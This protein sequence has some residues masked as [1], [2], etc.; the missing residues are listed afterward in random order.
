MVLVL[1][2]KIVPLVN[3]TAGDLATAGDGCCSC[4]VSN[5]GKVTAKDMRFRDY[6]EVST[7]EKEKQ[8]LRM[9]KRRR[10]LE[11]FNMRLL[12]SEEP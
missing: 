9:E 11:E 8:R 6:T 10:S 3:E 1:V 7:S 12:A 2:R 4:G 5:A